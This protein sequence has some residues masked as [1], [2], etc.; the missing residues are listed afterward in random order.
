M[1][2]I[3]AA[4][5]LPV[6]VLSLP[7]HSLLLTL[8]WP[9]Q[10]FWDKRE[11]KLWCNFES[12]HPSCNNLYISVSVWPHEV[13]VFN[14]WSLIKFCNLTWSNFT[15]SCKWFCMKRNKLNFVSSLPTRRASF[16]L[17]TSVHISCVGAWNGV[18]MHIVHYYWD[19]P[20][21][22][23]SKNIDNVLS[24]W[25]WPVNMPGFAAFHIWGSFLLL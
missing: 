6:E 16:R 14:E 11:I 4:V 12:L 24:M 9:W 22:W 15:T 25:I 7:V 17:L 1:A 23:L 5:V 19:Y 10:N 20:C 18:C 21:M 2:A 8:P 13:S 3:M